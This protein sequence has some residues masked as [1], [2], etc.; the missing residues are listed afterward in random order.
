M[1][2]KITSKRGF[3]IL[4]ANFVLGLAM[5]CGCSAA[6][7]GTADPSAESEA[8]SLGL[9]A[10]EQTIFGNGP[11]PSH[12][13]DP[14]GSA[15]E[16][17][18]KFRSSSSG[19]VTG[20]RFYKGSGNGGVHLGHLWSANGSQ[21]ASV[22]FSGETSSG[23]QTMH[24]PS[25]VAI[26]ANTTYVVSY[27]APRGRYAGDAHGMNAAHT[28]GPLTALADGAD[29]PNDVYVYGPSGFPT[30]TY[31]ATN[32][33][34]DVAFRP[35]AQLDAGGTDAR[36]TDSSAPDAAGTASV[37]AW[38]RGLAWYQANTG[39]PTGVTLRASPP[40]TVTTVGAVIDGLDVA[41]G[42]SV[43]AKNVT[44]RNTRV[45]GTISNDIGSLDTN[46]LVDHSE[47]DLS[48]IAIDASGNSNKYGVAAWWSVTVRFAKIHGMAQGVAFAGH[49]VVDDS[50]IYGIRSS[51]QHSECILSNGDGT[52]QAGNSSFHRNWLDADDT[53]AAGFV[54][55]AMS[56]YGD[57]GQI[58]NIVV[59][60]NYFTGA[61][62]NLYPGATS[63]KPYPLPLNVAVT[64]NVFNPTGY[65]PVYPS[66]LDP[67]STAAWANNGLVSGAVV[68]PP[69]GN[70]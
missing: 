66:A 47:M 20:V 8:A 35:D 12:P 61:G 38:T 31:Q 1:K 69:T 30:S 53:H 70:N 58:K 33:Y 34:V 2:Q 27:Y 48:A 32:Y 22:T 5:F 37:R 68:P 11:A 24:F 44:I 42:I 60:G 56:M 15:V 65:G 18:L 50:W 51:G 59:D 23:W 45:H 6:S 29:G 63:Q 64:N 39:V 36:P 14:D 54:S 57:Y 13:S 43:Q 40:L 21:L 16:L 28:T 19:S 9:V 52:A 4:E 25:P 26:L 3:R 46:L 67:A 55:S 62:Y 49:V 7:E 10:G 17:G 41:G